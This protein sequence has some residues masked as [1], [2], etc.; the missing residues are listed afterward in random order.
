MGCHTFPCFF[1]T[2]TQH[3]ECVKYASM[4]RLESFHLNLKLRSLIGMSVPRIVNSA[5]LHFLKNR[6]FA[7]IDWKRKSL[8][9]AP[10]R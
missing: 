4:N 8:F 9:S 1:R 7:I 10:I 3:G 5:I 6:H 2:F